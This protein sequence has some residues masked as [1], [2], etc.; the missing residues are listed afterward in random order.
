MTNNNEARQNQYSNKGV[1]SCVSSKRA[2]EIAIDFVGHGT[3]RE[4]FLFRVNGVLRFEVEVR[5][6]DVRSYVCVNGSN[7]A[8]IS[9][10]RHGDDFQSASTHAKPAGHRVPGVIGAPNDPPV[11]AQRAVELSGAHIVSL[12]VIDY[13]LDYIEVDIK[14]GRWVW[15]LEFDSR[16]RKDLGFCV[17]LNTGV[18]L[19]SPR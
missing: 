16:S 12:G 11:S 15:S 9:M 19:K 7:G 10:S 1:P 17:D 2:R 13:S 3:A 18:L 6:D 8:V 14:E 4:V 5:H